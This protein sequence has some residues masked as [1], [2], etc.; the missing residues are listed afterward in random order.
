MKNFLLIFVIFLIVSGCKTVTE[1]PDAEARA[2]AEAAFERNAET[3]LSL[4][5]SWQSENV[6]YSHYA[7]DFLAF[8]TGFNA[9]KDEVT[10]AEMIE[11]NAG[12]YTAFDFKLLSEPVMLPGVS[13][14]T[15]K[16]DGSV[17]YYGEW[18]VTRTATDSTDAKSGV[19]RIYQS[20]NFNDEG[21]I[22]YQMGYGDFTA[23]MNYLME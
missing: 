21:K 22:N 6:D 2:A 4:L 3:I 15:G 16:M 20:F 17:R 23:L 11:S 7:D 8:E 5:D 10:K 19:I 14:E 13:N 1:D 18:E 12:M 9:E